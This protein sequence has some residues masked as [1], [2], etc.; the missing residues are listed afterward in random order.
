MGEDAVLVKATLHILSTAS[1]TIGCG[2]LVLEL[3]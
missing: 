2:I 3:I 1:G